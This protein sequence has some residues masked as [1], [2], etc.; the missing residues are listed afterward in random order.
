MVF[1]DGVLFDG[2]QTHGRASGCHRC[3]HR[4]RSFVVTGVV[5]IVVVITTMVGQSRG[6]RRRGGH[7][8]FTVVVPGHSRDGSIPLGGRARRCGAR[9]RLGGVHLV[10]RPVAAH[11]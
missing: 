8:R 3:G 1:G 7:V 6:G 11:G 9:A 4:R 2:R 5:V 10:A